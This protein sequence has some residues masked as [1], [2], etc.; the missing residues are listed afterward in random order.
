VQRAKLGIQKQREVEIVEK[1]LN[2]EKN[3]AARKKLQ[4]HL[5]RNNR[6]EV[7]KV[8]AY[9]YILICSYFNQ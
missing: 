6:K 8:V 3:L 1:I 9:Y 4:P 7:I 2:E 5:C